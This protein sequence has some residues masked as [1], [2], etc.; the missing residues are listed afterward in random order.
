MLPAV[1]L[2]L[3]AFLARCTCGPARPRPLTD[4]ADAT[5]LTAAPS[6]TPRSGP[7]SEALAVP[8]RYVR[9]RHPLAP[10]PGILCAVRVRVRVREGRDGAWD[11]MKWLLGAN[12]QSEPRGNRCL[13][14][15]IF[16]VSE[17][18]D[19]EKID[20]PLNFSHSFTI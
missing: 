7:G 4:A 13:S 15:W 20:R 11:G 2:S 6:C 3:V 1:S 19:M 5:R 8:S 12:T 17:D 10:P 18:Q 16:F 9:P 14:L